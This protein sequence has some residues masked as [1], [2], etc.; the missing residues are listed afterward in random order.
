MMPSGEIDLADLAVAAVGDEEVA[1]A[2]QNACQ[3]SRASSRWHGP[4]LP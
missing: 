1:G 3:G 4:P 2:H